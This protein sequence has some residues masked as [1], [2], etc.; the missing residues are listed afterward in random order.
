MGAT[1]EEKI[2]LLAS[3]NTHVSREW[4]MKHIMDIDIVQYERRKKLNKI[5]NGKRS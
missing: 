4:I 1:I 5:L 2:K 3:L